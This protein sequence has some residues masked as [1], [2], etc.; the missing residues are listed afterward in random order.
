[1]GVRVCEM[2]PRHFIKTFTKT[3]GKTPHRYLTDLRLDFDECLLFEGKL[4]IA[5][6]TIFSGFSSQ[7]HLTAALTK[8]R[9]LKPA[10]LRHGR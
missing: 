8:H 1:M 3:F 7:S 10:Q 9:N 5:E 4:T 2:S 6:V